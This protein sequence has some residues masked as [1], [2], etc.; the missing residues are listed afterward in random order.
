MYTLFIRETFG[1]HKRSHRYIWLSFVM[2]FV[3]VLYIYIVVLFW[4]MCIQPCCGFL[5]L[6]IVHMHTCLPEFNYFIIFRIACLALNT[7][8]ANN[9]HWHSEHP[10]LSNNTEMDYDT[11]MPLTCDEG[12]WLNQSSSHGQPNTSQ[13]VK[14]GSNGDWT[15]DQ[16]CSRI[17]MYLWEDCLT[18]FSVV[19][20]PLNIRKKF[21][22]S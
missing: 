6:I 9:S 19:K 17:S 10:T 1:K 18:S 14:C 3:Y 8:H 5:W 22:A 20:H 4:Y 21:I 13:T 12:Y 16:H 2:L 15:A 11:S 7:K